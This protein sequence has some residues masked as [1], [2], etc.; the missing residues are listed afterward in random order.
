[1]EGGAQCG[2]RIVQRE[3]EIGGEQMG[4]ALRLPIR[5]LPREL[6]ELGDRPLRF[7]GTLQLEAGAS[8]SEP[9]GREPLCLPKFTEEGDRPVGVPDRPLQIARHDR[10]VREVVER[11]GL[12]RVGLLPRL[13]LE[14][15]FQ[16]SSRLGGVPAIAREESEVG[17]DERHHLRAGERTPRLV[18]P[19]ELDLVEPDVVEVHG[20][21][22][23]V[24]EGFGDGEG[25]AVFR[26]CVFEPPHL[27]ERVAE[28][29]AGA[30]EGSGVLPRL[31]NPLR[32]RERIDRERGLAEQA[33]D[34]AELL[35]R[36]RPERP[37][38]ERSRVLEALRERSLGRRKI[39]MATK[40]CAEVVE[41]LRSPLMV[42]GGREQTDRLAEE[43]VRLLSLFR[44]RRHTPPDPE[45]ARPGH[46]L[47]LH[48]EHLFRAAQRIVPRPPLEE[49]LRGFDEH[50]QESS[51]ALR[52]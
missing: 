19:G 5:G 11:T 21:L 32:F 44:Q 15:L 12:G 37:R 6:G 14:R 22:G 30:G 39:S 31:A 10:N 24:P 27:I 42:A 1:M 8:P 13:D 34:R 41:T 7:P 23:L 49:R 50:A 35:E 18:V 38:L 29:A 17:R 25:G 9:G 46:S 26:Q 16:P 36:S 20:D 40:R 3:G 45:G 2:L 4:V 43:P 52:T 48:L 33:K 51:H 47:G 28:R